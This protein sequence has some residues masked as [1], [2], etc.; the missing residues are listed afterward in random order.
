MK[1]LYYLYQ[2]V[3][4]LPVTILMTIWTA[5]TVGL[6]CTFGDGLKVVNIWSQTSRMSSWRIIRALLTS[7]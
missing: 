4:A 6:G 5:V 3:V 1:Y 7:F 2:L